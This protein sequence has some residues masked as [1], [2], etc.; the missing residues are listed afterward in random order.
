MVLLFAILSLWAYWR[1]ALQPKPV[2]WR[3]QA[4]L[5]LSAAGILYSHY[6]AALLLPVMSLFHLFFVPKDRRWWR[7]VLLLGAGCLTTLIQL[8]LFLQGLSVT[9]DGI[10]VSRPAL[11]APQLLAQFFQYLVN[12]IVDPPFLV[13]LLLAVLLPTGLVIAIL[14]LQRARVVAGA[15]WYLVFVSVTLLLVYTIANEALKVVTERRMRYLMALWPPLALLAGYGLCRL[16]G[17]HRWLATGLLAFWLL[18]G[19]WLGLATGYRYELGFF[20]QT[21][22]HLAYRAVDRHVPASE[23][24]VIDSEVSELEPEP[25]YLLLVDTPLVVYNRRRDDPLKHVLRL[26]AEYPYLWLLFHT[27]DKARMKAIASGL[28][29]VICERVQVAGGFTLTRHALSPVHCPDSSVRLAFDS[30]IQLTGP[31]IRLE[32]GRLL[33]Y[34]GFRSSDTGLLANY[35]LAVHLIDVNSGERVDQGDVGIGPG[36]FVPVSSEIDVSGLPPGDYEVRVALYD[37]Q[38]GVRL[39]ARDL[40]TDEVSDMHTLHRFRIG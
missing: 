14:L 10:S 1:I 31:D 40:E 8:P 28:G 21:E 9:A 11:L 30:D 7:P 16:Y 15:V 24:L 33:L 12:G 29:R 22:V 35:S 13:G 36:A 38:T 19:T 2:G 26:H 6:F 18:L 23:A 25:Y 20:N 5:M 39:Q 37:W 32:D 3:E 17:S 4:G 27:Q 34:A